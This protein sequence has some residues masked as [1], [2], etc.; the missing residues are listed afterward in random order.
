MF[1]SSE[2]ESDADENSGDVV[3]DTRQLVRHSRYADLRDGLLCRCEDA[4]SA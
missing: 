1:L 2:S 3:T 4:P